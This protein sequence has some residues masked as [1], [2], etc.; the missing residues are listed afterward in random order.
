MDLGLKLLKVLWML[1]KRLG[2]NAIERD[3][4]TGGKYISNCFK[5]PSTLTIPENC[6]YIGL[7]AFHSC[8]GL[9]KVIISRSV[10]E[11]GIGAFRGCRK[12]EKVTVL[13]SCKRIGEV[14]FWD[15]K[16]LEKV[17]IP[18]SVELIESCAFHGCRRTTIILKKPRKKFNFIA[19]SAF[20]GV[21]HVKEEIWN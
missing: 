12:L 18:K 6:K 11:I 9:R 2:L 15:C 16:R 13:E 8:L 3:W 7:N 19:S 10:V 5:I 14:A 17:I 21:R 1:K 20:E 4:F